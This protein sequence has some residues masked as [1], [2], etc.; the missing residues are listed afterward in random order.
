MLNMA[1]GNEITS[2]KFDSPES[3]AAL[4]TNTFGFFLNRPD[5]LPPLPTCHYLTWPAQS[6]T[7]EQTVS[8]PWRGGRHPVLDALITTPDAVIGI[9]SKR[10]E[11]FRSRK[12]PSMSDA[13]WRPVWGNKMKGYESIRDNIRKSG[14]LFSHLDGAQLF[15]HAFA[16]RTQ[17]DR[18]TEHKGLIPI[19]F[20]LYAEPQIWPNSGRKIAR[21]AK[22][23]HR[24]EIEEF[25]EVVMNDEVLFIHCSYRNLLWDWQNKQTIS[26]EI[27]AHAENVIQRFA[28]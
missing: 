26:P 4:A 14:D 6:V 20:Y 5:I 27:H 11:P 3:S 1:Q 10:F 2:G 16:L 24:E 23:K 8:F 12:V 7:L 15:K 25:S 13:Y 22:D 18:R 28:P 21:E 17:V 9:E 19:L